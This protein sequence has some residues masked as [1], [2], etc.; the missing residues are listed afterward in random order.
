MQL[1][2]IISGQKNSISVLQEKI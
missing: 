2:S 1:Q